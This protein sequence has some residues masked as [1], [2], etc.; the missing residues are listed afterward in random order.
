MK[1]L[2]LRYK[3][4]DIALI[5]DCHGRAS[6]QWYYNEDTQQIIN[7]W[8]AKCLETDSILN[9]ASIRVKACSAGFQQRWEFDGHQIK[10][11]WDKSKC[12]GDGG[13]FMILIRCDSTNKNQIFYKERMPFA[14]CAPEL[15]GQCAGISFSRADKLYLYDIHNPPADN[16]LWYYDHPTKHILSYDG[17]CVMHT[18]GGEAFNRPNGLTTDDA[19][20]GDC[21]DWTISGTQLDGSDGGCM[22]SSGGVNGRLQQ[23]EPCD[24]NKPN[25]KFQ[26]IASMLLSTQ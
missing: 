18:V 5:S 11:S 1:G 22:E 13:N 14:I 26:L 25:Q 4:Q 7:G 3:A 24:N 20:W 12:I 17:G 19:Y 16:Q 15:D 21:I 2:C 23:Y 6:Q 10:S 9:G 8:D